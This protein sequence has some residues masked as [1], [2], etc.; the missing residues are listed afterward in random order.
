MS[1][2]FCSQQKFWHQTWRARDP[3]KF[4]AEVEHLKGRFGIDVFFIADEYPT[5]D[6]ERWE[7]ILD[8][9]IEKDLG[10]SFLMETRVEDIIRDADIL[11]KYRRAGIIHIYV[12]VEATSQATLDKFNK[13]IKVDQSKEAL[14][15][16]DEAGIVSETSFVLG[17][18][19]DNVYSIRQTLKLAQDYNPDFAHFLLLAPW[20][21]AD[22]YDDLK[23]YIEEK[24]Y[25]QYNLVA[26]VIKPTAMTRDQLFS[27]VLRCYRVF[28]MNKLP[29]W[30]STDDDFKKRY[31]LLSMK[32]IANHSF[33]EQHVLGLGKMPKLIEKYLAELE[34]MV[35]AVK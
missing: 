20:P 33:L 4:V 8:K 5:K 24:D 30:A 15:L 7:T 25:S 6:R 11:S 22:M 16:I 18:P 19:E 23:P 13:S 29:E 2:S 9:L 21:Y 26:P 34:S 17:M 1:C 10:L 3:E 28:Y 27:E 12:G 35:G 32:A 31:A 14:R